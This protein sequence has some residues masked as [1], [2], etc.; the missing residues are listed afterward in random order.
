MFS[1]I[2]FL[3]SLAI[4]VS[5]HDSVIIPQDSLQ[6]RRILVDLDVAILSPKLLSCIL[7]SSEIDTASTDNA[8][9]CSSIG[10]ATNATS[11]LVAVLS[12]TLLDP[13]RFKAGVIC[14]G[15]GGYKQ[16]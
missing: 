12:L 2:C 7:K 11:T 15:N 14:R 4:F 9:R 10:V 16:Q 6:S 8:I 13:L 1:P 3:A 5:P